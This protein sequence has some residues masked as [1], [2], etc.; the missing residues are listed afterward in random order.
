MATSAAEV[1]LREIDAGTVRAICA[2]RVAPA[3]ECLVAPNAISIAQAHFEPAAWFRAIYVD[4]APV[5]FAM[6]FDP[7]RGTAPER[8]DV[9]YLWRFMIAEEHQRHGY[10]G[11]ALALLIAHARTLGGVSRFQLS[12]VPEAAGPRDFYARFGFRETGEIDAGEVVMELVL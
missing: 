10:G 4:T 11:A 2:L 8:P 3:Q 6:L 12:Y 7:T 9:C 5:G 1:T